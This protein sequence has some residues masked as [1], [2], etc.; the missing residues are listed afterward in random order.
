MFIIK[1]TSNFNGTPLAEDFGVRY[2][3]REDA[4][5]D[6]DSMAESSQGVE[7]EIVEETPATASSIYDGAIDQVRRALHGVDNGMPFGGVIG[8]L[9]HALFADCPASI[10]PAR[11]VEDLALCLTYLKHRATTDAP[12]WASLFATAARDLLVRETKGGT[13]G[14]QLRAYCNEHHN[15]RFRDSVYEDLFDV[16]TGRREG[17]NCEVWTLNQLFGFFA[18]HPIVIAKGGRV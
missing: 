6:V 13:I 5:V 14:E 11:R 1:L 16:M 10:T 9:E 8:A 3:T 12:P 17:N 7:F 4:Q 2:D 18:D 15:E